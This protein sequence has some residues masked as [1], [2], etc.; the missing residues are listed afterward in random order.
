[1]NSQSEG[2]TINHPEKGAI[3]LEFVWS[4]HRLLFQEEN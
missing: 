2:E 1:M 3:N 4:D